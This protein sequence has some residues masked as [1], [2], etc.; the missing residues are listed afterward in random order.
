MEESVRSHHDLTIWK[1]SIELAS[2]IYDDTQSFP[3]DE[4]YSLVNQM[5][6]AAVSIPS[7]IAEGSERKSAKSFI[8]FLRIANGSLAELETQLIISNKLK[9][10]TTAKESEYQKHIISL[11]KRI[12]SL[13]KYLKEK[14]D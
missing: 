13:V 6:R 1:D 11:K 4:L 2:N 12:Y 5:R 14:G 3:D 9:F 10:I 7:N 8:H